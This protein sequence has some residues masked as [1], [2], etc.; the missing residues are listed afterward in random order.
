MTENQPNSLS[1]KSCVCVCVRVCVCTCVCV[2]VNA[3]RDVCK[4]SEEF[5]ETK[6][7]PYVVVCVKKKRKAKMK[8]GRK[9]TKACS[10]NKKTAEA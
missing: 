10:F 8:V 5:Q 7:T 2:C 4:D 9:I 1:Q 6:F 3:L